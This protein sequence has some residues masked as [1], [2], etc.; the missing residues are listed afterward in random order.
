MGTG[1]LLRS[2]KEAVPEVL[3]GK[4]QPE[5]AVFLSLYGLLAGLSL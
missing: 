2:G 5:G 1:A 3:G 4:T